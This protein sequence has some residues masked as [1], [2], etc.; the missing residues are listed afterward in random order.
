VLL[1]GEAVKTRPPTFVG[2]LAADPKN[3]LENV[4]FHPAK[5]VLA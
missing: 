2:G 4:P 3:H 1:R 5:M